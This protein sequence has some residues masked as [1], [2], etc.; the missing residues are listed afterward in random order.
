MKIKID[1]FDN[2]NVHDGEYVFI[3]SKYGKFTIHEEKKG[4][5]VMETTDIPYNLISIT[6]YLGN[7]IYIKRKEDK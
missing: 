1:S 3:E 2:Q 4:L 7:T 6:P 5:M